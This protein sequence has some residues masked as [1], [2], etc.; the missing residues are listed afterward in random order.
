ML[1]QAYNL[2]AEQEFQRAIT[3]LEQIP[4]DTPAGAIAKEKLPEYQ[5]K[6]R[7]IER[8]G[9][10]MSY[11]PSEEATFVSTLP[12]FSTLSDLNPGAQLQEVG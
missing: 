4:A 11:H 2:A 9:R 6:Q 5:Q 3:F 12:S 10:R 7:I 1:Q 8:L